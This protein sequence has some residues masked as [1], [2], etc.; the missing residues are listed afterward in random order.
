M[1][2]TQLKGSSA[3][4]GLEEES[5]KMSGKIKEL[6]VHMQREK[7]KRMGDFGAGVNDGNAVFILNDTLATL[8]ASPEVECVVM[9]FLKNCGMEKYYDAFISNQIHDLPALKNLTESALEAIKIPIGHRLKIL[10]NLRTFLN[11]DKTE[12]NKLNPSTQHKET[13]IKDLLPSQPFFQLTEST[14]IRKPFVTKDFNET[15]LSFSIQAKV[16]CWQCLRVHP[17]PDSIKNYN[18][19]FCSDSCLG[20]FESTEKKTCTCG[21]IFLRKQGIFYKEMWICNLCA[22]KIDY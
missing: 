17:E 20:K 22:E 13:I 4:F 11:S 12:S 3:G 9:M 1:K 10:K 14:S 19:N 2:E 16:P 18:K 15:A 8:S 7:E 5:K 6:Q 21:A